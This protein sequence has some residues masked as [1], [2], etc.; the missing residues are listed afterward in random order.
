MRLAVDGDTAL[1]AHERFFRFPVRGFAAFILARLKA[2]RSGHQRVPA[3][4]EPTEADEGC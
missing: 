4:I 2:S 3:G 1:N